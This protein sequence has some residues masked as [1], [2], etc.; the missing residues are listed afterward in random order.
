[1][2][3]ATPWQKLKDITLPLVLYA[4][5]PADRQYAGN[6]NHGDLPLQPGRGGAGTNRRRIGHID[7]L[8]IQAHL[9]TQKFNYAA[10]V[11]VIIGVIVAVWPSGS[12]ENPILPG[13]DVD[14]M[15]GTKR[16]W[17]SACC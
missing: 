5:A 6:F 17:S 1:M 3:G 10:A 7:F 2:D 11:S 12:S 9:E 4:T 13:R 15:S 8:G 14:T 16:K